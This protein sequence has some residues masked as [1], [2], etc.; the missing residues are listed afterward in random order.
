M[1]TVYW[2]AFVAAFLVTLIEMTEV[3]ALV[4]AFGA[5]HR[6]IRHGA[7]GAVSG[8][9]VVGAITLA[10]AAVLTALP[11][12]SLLWGSAVV[13]VAFGLFI[14]RSTLRSF[15][16]ARTP[17]PAGAPSPGRRADAIQFA[18][19]FSVGTVET[20]EAAIVLVA[21]AAAGYGWTALI[22]ALSAGAILIVAAAT[23][24][25]R[26]R[27]IKVPW[28]KAG[29]TAVI[30]SFALFWGGEAAGV[31]WPGNDLILLPMFVVGL[32]LVRGAVALD[33]TRDVQLET[34][35]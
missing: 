26:I 8:T 21:L 5:D 2:P 9:A 30:F 1:L 10:S 23:L 14:G 18:G 25:E 11:H 17:A 27:R 35:R 3:V 6:S 15:R 33:T 4:F 31:D 22:G 32:V 20:V 12:T 7:L 19:G 16:R 29:A 28:L 13:L 34:K 24:H